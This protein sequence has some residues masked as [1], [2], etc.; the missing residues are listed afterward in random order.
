MNALPVKEMTLKQALRA[1]EKAALRELKQAE[2][3]AAKQANAIEKEKKSYQSNL[4]N[5]SEG[6]KLF[7][8]LPNVTEWSFQEKINNEF[9]SLG[10]YLSS[11]PLK[12]YT[13]IFSKINI[14]TSNEL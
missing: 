2:K 4:F 12:S 5:I 9:L 1:K 6:N 3:E 8:E 10:L 7:I 11:H 14:K 13:N